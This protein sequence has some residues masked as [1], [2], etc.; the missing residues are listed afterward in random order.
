MSSDVETRANFDDNDEAQFYSHG[1]LVGAQLIP[2][3]YGVLS[4]TFLRR[5]SLISTKQVHVLF[6]R[7]ASGAI[8][9]HFLSKTKT[10]RQSSFYFIGC[11]EFNF[12]TI[13]LLYS[14]KILRGFDGQ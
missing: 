8:L 11:D 2:N 12:P 14:K 7:G 9:W 5:E 10:L 1:R 13:A 3:D 6:S 4:W